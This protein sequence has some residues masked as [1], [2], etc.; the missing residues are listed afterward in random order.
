[1]VRLARFSAD[2]IVDAAIALVAEAGPSA[3][4]M[5]AIARKVGAPT[6]SLYHRFD[7]RA[8]ILATAWNRTH[9]SF[10]AALAPPLRAGRP[11]AAAAAL[12][13][14]VREDGRRARFL[15]LNEGGMPADD[16]PP[17]ALRDEQRRLEDELDAAFGACLAVLNPDGP[18]GEE[19]TART[20]FLV[21]DGPIALVRPHLLAGTDVPDYVDR[22]VADLHRPAPVRAA[23]RVA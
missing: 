2:V 18:A 1:M 17:A 23:A 20:K 8:A 9:A 10:V 12:L 16:A 3:A 7:S 14:W 11:A 22:L 6:G 4:T 15:L 21:F 19:S 13:A 5:A